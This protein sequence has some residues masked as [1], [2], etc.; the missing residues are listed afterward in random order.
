MAVTLIEQLE[1]LLSTAVRL[2]AMDGSAKEIA[3]LANSIVTAE[4]TGYA[5]WNN[6]CDLYTL[7]LKVQLNLYYQIEDEKSII[8]ETILNKLNSIIHSEHEW[9]EKVVLLPELKNDKDWRDKANNWL[10][11]ETIS[12]QGRVRSDNIASKSCDGLLFRSQPE[13]Y[14]YKALKSLGVSFAPLAVFIRGGDTY[15][16]IEPDFVI[17]KDG[18]ICAV[19]IDGDTVHQETPAEAHSRTT[20][21]LHEGVYIE[22]ISSSECDT[23]AKA[24]KSAKKIIDII[25]KVKNAK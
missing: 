15:H 3:I 1:S 16:R 19:E 5:G 4:P 24:L 20:M 22:R 6:D 8:Q 7:F 13:I 17:I 14:F 23:D 12:N 18:I 11:G 2:F 9:F 21:L 25:N 10:K